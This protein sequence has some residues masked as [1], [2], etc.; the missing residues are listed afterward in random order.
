MLRSTVLSVRARWKREI[1]SF[2]LMCAKSALAMP[3]LPSR[4]SKSIG[5]TLCGLLVRPGLPAHRLLHEVAEADVAPGVARP[6]D[7]DRVATLEGIEQLG[8]GVV[9]LDLRR[10]RIEGE[11]EA[12]LDDAPGEGFPVEPGI[13]REVGVVVADRAVHLREQAHRGDDL[14]GAQEAHGDGGDLLAERRRA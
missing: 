2:S 3:K 12:L 5:F 4:F 6:V 13:G 8:H 10:I 9:R 11:A 14:A 7:E 1:G